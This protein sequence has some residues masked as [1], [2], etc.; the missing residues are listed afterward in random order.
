MRDDILQ[1]KLEKLE[2]IKNA[3]MDPYPEKTNRD[4]SNAEV[5]HKFDEIGNKKITI[6]LAFHKC[7]NGNELQ[8]ERGKVQGPEHNEEENIIGGTGD[9]FTCNF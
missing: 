8:K 1:T 9:Y 3:G 4:F 5:A 2:N 7:Y 6:V